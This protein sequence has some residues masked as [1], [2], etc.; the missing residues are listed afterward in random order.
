MPST[1]PDLRIPTER[2]SSTRATGATSA[3]GDSLTGGFSLGGGAGRAG[4]CWLGAWPPP[5]VGRLGHSASNDSGCPGRV[6]DRNR[7]SRRGPLASTA[8][9]GGAAPLVALATGGCSVA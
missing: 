4:L 5:L 1:T 3:A 7:K 2:G 8:A 6:R 9:S